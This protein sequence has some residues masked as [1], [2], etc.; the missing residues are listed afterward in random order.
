MRISDWS[1]DVCSSDLFPVHRIYCVGR[2]FAEHARE[3]GSEIDRGTPVFFMKPADAV[4]PGGGAQ[5]FPSATG[6]MHHEVEL[7]VALGRDA[8]GEVD[9]G[10]AMALVLGYPLGLGLTRRALQVGIESSWERVCPTG[11][12]SLVVLPHKK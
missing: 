7:V 8:D 3:M 4:L 9:A 11:E 2:N 5:P 12:L 10:H 6:D 1:S